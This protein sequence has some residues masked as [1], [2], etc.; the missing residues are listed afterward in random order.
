MSATRFPTVS[1]VILAGGLARRMGGEDKGLVDFQG[2]PLIN[3]VIKRL[4]PQVDQLL[5]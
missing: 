4:L 2:Q 5:R 3:H 1:G